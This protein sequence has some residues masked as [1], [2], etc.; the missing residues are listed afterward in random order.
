MPTATYSGE[1]KTLSQREHAFEL[2]RLALHEPRFDAEPVERVRGQITAE[3]RRLEAEPNYL[4][5]RAWFERAFPGQSLW[6]A[7]LGHA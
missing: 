3:L 5:S 1:L 2:L 6:P 7:D 4:A